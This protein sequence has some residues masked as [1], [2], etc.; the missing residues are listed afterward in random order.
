MTTL[1]TDDAAPK[2]D[3][4]AIDDAD[5]SKTGSLIGNDLIG[6]VVDVLNTMSLVGDDLISVVIH[7]LNTTG[8]LRLS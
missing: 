8:R 4:I 6:V 3:T 7:V 2:H 1:R 5:M